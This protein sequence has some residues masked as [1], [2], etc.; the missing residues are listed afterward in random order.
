[1]YRNLDK[2]VETMTI[3]EEPIIKKELKEMLELYIKDN[4]KSRILLQ[5]GSYTKVKAE[6]KNIHAQEDML[7]LCKKFNNKV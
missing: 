6:G 5:D 7:E 1:M 2:R 3:I 4:V